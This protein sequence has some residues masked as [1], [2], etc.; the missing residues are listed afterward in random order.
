MNITAKTDQERRSELERTRR[1]RV[2]RGDGH[3]HECLAD[4]ILQL[5][6]FHGFVSATFLDDRDGRRRACAQCRNHLVTH[7]NHHL[8]PI[9]RTENGCEDKSASDEEHARAY[10]QHDAHA[11]TIIRFFLAQPYATG[12]VMRPCGMKI[13]VYTRWD[14]PTI[15]P[16][17]LARVIGRVGNSGDPVV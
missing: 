12:R 14:S 1:K 17:G 16:D 2:G 10:L 15:D 8:H 6:S 4:S 7:V 3:N 11:E 5:L 13:R 9:V